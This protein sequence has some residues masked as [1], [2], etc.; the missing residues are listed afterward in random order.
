M[1]YLAVIEPDGFTES[2]FEWKDHPDL[3][4]ARNEL[5]ELI[6]YAYKKYLHS[7]DRQDLPRSAHLY[8]AEEPRQKLADLNV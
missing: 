1:I 2:H 8:E 3:D 7:G 4:S 5:T 6:N